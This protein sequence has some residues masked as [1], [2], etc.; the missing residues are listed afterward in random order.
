MRGGRGGDGGFGGYGLEKV[1]SGNQIFVQV[2]LTDITED[3][4]SH[5][6]FIRSDYLE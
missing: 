1:K 2:M 4:V 6:F 3:D 5:I